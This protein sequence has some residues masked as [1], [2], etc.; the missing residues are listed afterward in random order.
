[1]RRHERK[2]LVLPCRVRA[3]RFQIEAGI[4]LDSADLSEGGAFLRADLLFEV[5]ETLDLEIPLPTGAVLKA[6]GRVVRVAR[7]GQPTTPTGM[8]IEFTDLDPE[9]RRLIQ[10][11]T[12]WQR[13]SR[14]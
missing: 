4:Q 11:G 7:G 8:G 9:G 12:P 1:M 3:R 5:G 2:P 6:G 13:P 14:S 10:E